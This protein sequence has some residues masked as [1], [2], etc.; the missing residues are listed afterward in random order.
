MNKTAKH[1]F[2]FDPSPSNCTAINTVFAKLP[3]I[4]TSPSNKTIPLL[5]PFIALP[6]PILL[7][8]FCRSDKAT[9]Q[10]LPFNSLM[11]STNA[12]RHLGVRS[13]CGSAINAYPPSIGC[14][15]PFSLLVEVCGQVIAWKM[16]H[17]GQLSYIGTLVLVDRNHVMWA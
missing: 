8:W 15:K 3:S 16:A 4:S 5:L 14:T 9:S 7:L 2:D 10:M 11:A 17:S 12:D 6:N 13:F 1:Y